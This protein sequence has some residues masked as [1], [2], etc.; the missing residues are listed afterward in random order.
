MRTTLLTRHALTT[1]RRITERE[2]RTRVAGTVLGVFHYVLT[3]LFFLGVYS[4]VFSSVFTTRW[5]GA[6]DAFGQFALNLY[7]GLIPFHF[8]SEVLNRSSG[9]VLENPT[10]VKKVVFPLEILGPA[11]MGTALTCGLIGYG[12]FLAGYLLMLG[13]PPLAS[14]SL[15]ALWPPLLLGVAGLSWIL[16][17]FGVFLRDLAQMV[18]AILPALMF[19]TPIFYPLEMVPPAIRPILHG[20]PLTYFIESMRAAVF[21]GLWPDP[22]GL[23]LAWAGGGALAL[24]GLYLFLRLKPAF[25]DVV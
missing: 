4:V 6:S 2:L 16:S 5:P 20:N 7:A 8:V 1:I 18:T 12:I 11:V 9:L 23:A 21:Q 25:A 14:L 17:A 13:V 19:V 3:P 24:L 10:Y 22:L 15:L